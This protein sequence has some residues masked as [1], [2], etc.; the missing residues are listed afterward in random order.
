[1]VRSADG[2]VVCNGHYNEP[3]VPAIPGLQTFSGKIQHS[4]WWR[5]AKRIRGQN[6]LVIG[7]RASGSDIARETA[8]D[9]EERAGAGEVVDR[10]IY[11]SIRSNEAQP[12]NPEDFWDKRKIWSSRIEVVGEVDKI[13]G[14][15][16]WLRGGRLLEDVD[17]IIF[18]TGY[19]YS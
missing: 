11:Q 1:M 10:G 7:G 5:S 16:V 3:F 19:L 14:E 9:D 8:I 12:T 13:E 6:V 15:K 17:I 2:T 4:R 18:A